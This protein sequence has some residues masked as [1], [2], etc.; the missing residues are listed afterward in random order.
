MNGRISARQV[1]KWQQP[2]PSPSSTRCS[3]S[4]GLDYIRRTQ[5]ATP[6]Q[7]PTQDTF[8]SQDDPSVREKVLDPRLG[9]CVPR[10]LRFF[11]QIFWDKI[12]RTSD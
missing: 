7:D 6:D 11:L 5:R 10:V 4:W 2:D 12:G 9:G 8:Y 3:R 1:T